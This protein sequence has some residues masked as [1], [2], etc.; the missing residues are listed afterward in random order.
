MNY[1][2]LG[3]N[4]LTSRRPF[5]LSTLIKMYNNIIYSD[6][7]TIWI[8]DPR[9][10]F[11][12][13]AIDFWAQIDGVIEGSPYFQGYVPFICT[14]FLALKSTRKTLKMLKKWQQAVSNDRHDQEQNLLQKI[15]FELS[16]NFGVL[17]V[18]NFPYGLMYFNAMGNKQR[19]DVVILHNNYVFGKEKKI[20]RFRDFQLW[21]PEFEKD[22]M[23]YKHSSKDILQKIVFQCL[24]DDAILVGTVMAV[25][26]GRILLTEKSLMK[27]SK[28]KYN[29]FKK[30]I[31]T[32]FY[33]ANIH[34]KTS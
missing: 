10:Y 7:D 20:Q 22:S 17:P 29:H 18:R 15:A 30:D 21:A 3:F 24:L 6:I 11:K 27:A 8:G 25:H 14:G 9:P 19:S 4:I 5:Y 33:H 16:M 31:A 1:R 32:Y 23:C 28:Q 13:H 2:S 26:P 12:G 34:W